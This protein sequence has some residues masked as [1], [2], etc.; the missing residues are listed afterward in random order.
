MRK[1]KPEQQTISILGGPEDGLETEVPL[2]ED[3]QL[4]KKITRFGRKYVMLPILMA[5]G[6]PRYLYLGNNR[7]EDRK[8]QL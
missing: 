7:I 8:G 6:T 5:D 1:P 4:P 3:G 2:D